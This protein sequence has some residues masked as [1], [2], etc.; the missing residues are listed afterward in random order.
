MLDAL[1]QDIRYA[2]RALRRNPGFAAVT[3]FSLALGM[4]ANTAIFSL[5]DVVMLKSLPVSH[6]EELVQVTMGSPLYFSN[7]IWEQIRDRQDVF[8]G[9]FAYGKWPF[10]LAHGGEVRFVNGQYVSGQYFDTLGVR[11]MLGRTLTSADD[12]RGCVGTAVLSHGFWQREYG[13]RG[14]ILGKTISIYDHPFEIVGVTQPGFTGVEVGL[15]VDVWIPICADRILNGKDGNLDDSYVPGWLQIMGRL[16]PGVQPSQA[17][18]R[19]E[20]L[21]P[22]VFR[23]TVAANWRDEDRDTFLKRTL[24]AQPA[25]N[26]LS[27][28]RRNYRQALLILMAIAGVVLL[29]AC[30]NVANLLLARGAVRERELAI[31]IAL[32]SGR[33]RLIRQL[34]AESLLLSAAGTAVGVV[35]ALWATR[36]LV[37]FLDV[38]LDLTP[39]LRMLAFNAGVAVATGLLFGVA[40]AW[41]S[42]RVQPQLAMKANARGVIGSSGFGIGKAL[43]TL[44]VALSVVLVVGA[45]LL[46]ASLWR[47]TSVD[48]GLKPER[49]LVV[50]VDL[51]PGNYAPEHRKAKFHE[52]LEKLRAIPGVHSLSASNI[53]PMCGC[54]STVNVV[55]SGF[56]AR[57]RDDWEVA[58]NLVSDGYFETLGTPMVTGRDFSA[59]DTPTSSKVAIINESMARK[60]FG[61]PNPL[62]RYVR[63]HEANKIGDPYEIVGVVNDAKYGTLR[64]EIS[65]TLYLTRNQDADSGQY[66]HFELRTIGGRPEALIEQAKSAIAGIDRGASLEFSPL[67][68][69]I[70]DSLSRDRLL[71]TLSGI[72]G[73][74]A[75]VLA[76]MG[77]Y[78]VMSYNVTWRRGEIAIRMALGAEQARVVRM[79]LREVL[80]MVG[81]GLV[82][83]LSLAMAMTRFIASFLYGLTP[84]DPLTLSLAAA[85]LAGV[86]VFA[87]YLPARRASRVDPMTALREE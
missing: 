80:L 58:F 43:V 74:L 53:M 33:G 21:A 20:T 46:L 32:G 23:A 73:A 69:T 13:G 42:T 61:V 72:F 65:P 52:I 11:A 79:V 83:G 12:R 39:D 56:T 55:V 78:G 31:R 51:R 68:A 45:G 9:I 85:A 19:L 34:L 30:A 4:G 29:I 18:A 64:E 28:L 26:G 70:G 66:V 48:A 59:H 2:I 63:I 35:F 82:V 1:W 40:P 86:G 22:Q 60:Y 10:N 76:M 50:S 6:P 49:V 62:G 47:L 84:N 24:D 7:L 71:A 44:Q 14:D 5:I 75:L 25:A 36:L 87:G 3:V 77:L 37:A 38:S 57:S 54:R 27:W 15:S 17:R 81:T 41:R 16:K 8:S 67:S